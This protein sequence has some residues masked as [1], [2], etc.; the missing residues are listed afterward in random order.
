M[1]VRLKLSMHDYHVTG[2]I[3]MVIACICKS[4]P[5]QTKSNPNTD[6]DLLR[7]SLRRR[8]PRRNRRLQEGL[9]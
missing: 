6:V 5:V 3:W 4:Y 2:F 1:S 7:T 9:G 8:Y